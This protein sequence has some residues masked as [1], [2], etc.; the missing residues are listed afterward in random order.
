MR[1]AATLDKAGE[2]DTAKRLGGRI[3][4]ASGQREDPML[5]LHDQP[6]STPREGVAQWLGIL[7]AGM[8]REPNGSA[9]LP[10]LFAPAA[11]W[12]D[13]EDTAVGNYLVIT[14]KPHRK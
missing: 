7:A 14:L 6:V 12:H 2:N 10:L 9:K 13:H 4:L 5:L 11:S 8:A 3:A 1:V